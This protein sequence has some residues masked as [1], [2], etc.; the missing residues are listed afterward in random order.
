[1]RMRIALFLL[2]LAGP[3]LAETCLAPQDRGAE[4]AALLT[5]LAGS[6]SPSEGIAAANA[7]W[8]F[9][10]RAP[11]ARAQD[12]LDTGMRRMREADFAEAERVLTT[13]VT[14]CPDF[15]E[16]WNQRAFARFL[17]QRLDESLD[18][19]AEA[20]AREP[21]HFGALSGQAQIFVRQG[22]PKMAQ[23]AL[24]RAVRVHPWLQER[25][26]IIDDGGTDI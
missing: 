2:F 21:A 26:L 10:T 24:R 4:R 20:L 1:M 11:D 25:A 7:L 18:D 16:G 19:I 12:L 17:D 22:R 15:A 9:W 3:A 13:L 6:G 23:A 8:A 5:D 14:Y